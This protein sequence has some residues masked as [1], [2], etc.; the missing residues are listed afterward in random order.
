MQSAV[1]ES[2]WVGYDTWYKKGCGFSLSLCNC[3]IS[4][5]L[6]DAFHE[7]SCSQLSLSATGCTSAVCLLPPCLVCLLQEI[8]AFPPSTPVFLAKSVAALAEFP[9][10]FHTSTRMETVTYLIWQLPL[11]LHTAP[12]HCSCPWAVRSDQAYTV[13]PGRL[14]C[15]Q[16]S[17]TFSEVPCKGMP[18]PARNLMEYIPLQFW[19][20]LGL[21]SWQVW[22]LISKAMSHDGVIISV[23]SHCAVIQIT[24]VIM[25]P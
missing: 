1:T 13:Q 11:L 16:S 3:V 8:L 2:S 25:I 5:P 6:S 21:F 10:K 18:R 22:L 15:Q 7:A 19:W 14:W 23:H 4:A 12:V 24:F 9:H 17:A 20:F